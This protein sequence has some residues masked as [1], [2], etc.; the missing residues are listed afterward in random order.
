MKIEAETLARI[1]RLIVDVG[2]EEIGCDE[3]YQH[4]DYF[5]ELTLRGKN[6]SEI[7]PLVQDHL[8]RCKG[9]REEFEV[10]LAALNASE[11]PSGEL[12]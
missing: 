6:A 3:C 5:A 4:L 11:A 9:C 10:L 1:L 8:K 2:P 7:L 12:R